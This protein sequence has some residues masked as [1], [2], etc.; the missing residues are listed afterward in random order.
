MWDVSAAE[1]AG[2]QF[3]RISRQ[4]LLGLGVSLDAI[5]HA[6]ATGQLVA[7]CEGVFAF[8]PV[9]RHDDWGRWMAA[10]L[11]A[12]GSRLSLGWA[13]YAWGFWYRPSGLITVTRPGS[14]GPRRMSGVK[15]FRSTTVATESTELRGIPITSVE[16]TLMDLARNASRPALARGVR[17]AVGD[18]IT[19]D[20]LTAFVLE[21]SK[22][23]CAG[24]M[25]RILAE[26]S[27]LPLERAR[28]GAE[29]KALTLLRD[30]G[31]PMPRLNVR[32]AGEEADLSWP[33]LGLIVE[34]DG[35]PYHQDV[36]EDAR[37]EAVWRDAGWEVRR[38]PSDDVYDRP[39]S[40][41]ARCPASVPRD[42]S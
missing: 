26:Y 10:T 7:V 39:G 12:P 25:L 17:E 4:Q 38:V 32:I 41:L 27:G 37:K 42:G 36:G 35:T 21:R 18:L 23:R 30:A 22:R 31:R 19:L 8:A 11:T 1:L 29:V 33:E 13:G 6:V 3:N 15:A 24:R 40:F 5:A 14:G 16:R 28:S 34:I 2:E 20:A 9:L